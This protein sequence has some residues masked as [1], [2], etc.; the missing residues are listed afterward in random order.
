[1]PAETPY[2]PGAAAPVRVR[3]V[4]P[5]DH[6]DLL[7][8]A[9]RLLIGMAP[10]R[11]P[12]KML[13]FM[14]DAIAASL[15]M[16]TDGDGVDAAVFVAVDSRGDRLGFVTVA[17]NVDFTGD[18]QAYVGELAVAAHAEGAGVGQALMCAAEEWARAQG[19]RLIVL[20]TGAANARARALYARRGYTEESVRLVKILDIEQL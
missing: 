6:D 13:A 20:D 17:R 9:P 12:D 16:A 1:M 15:D 7:S 14:R 10:W 2:L 4:I 5:A 19:Y 3:P 8:L 11:E 18:V